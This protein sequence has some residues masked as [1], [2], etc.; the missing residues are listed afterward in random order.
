MTI[1]PRKVFLCHSKLQK[2][3]RKQQQQ[4]KKRHTNLFFFDLVCTMP[5]EV[6]YD[7]LPLF[8]FL[9]TKNF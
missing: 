8:F 5:L 9:A 6:K 1:E 7:S 4:Q 3:K 2:E